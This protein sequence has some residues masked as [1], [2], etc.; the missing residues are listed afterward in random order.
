MSVS[1]SKAAFI[2]SVIIAFLFASLAV[3]KHKANII[4]L[5]NHEENKFHFKKQEGV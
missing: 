5:M 3:Y 1:S 4:R 2:E